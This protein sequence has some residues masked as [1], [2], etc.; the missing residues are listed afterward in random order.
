MK[1]F[2]QSKSMYAWEAIEDGPYVPRTEDGLDLP[3]FQWTRY[4][5]ERVKEN[6][7]AMNMI[8]C[9]L[10]TQEGERVAVC[11]SAKEMWEK[12]QITYEGTNKV[13]DAKIDL[14]IEQI[15]TFKMQHGESV[16]DL[17]NRYLNLANELKRLGK[18]Y[19][20]EEK[21][22]KILRSLTKE[23]DN[24]KTAIEEAKDLKAYTYD[25]LI[26][27]LL[28]HDMTH[29][30]Y[31]AQAKELKEEKK[32]NL[33]LRAERS[34]SDSSTDDE[35]DMAAFARKFRRFMRKE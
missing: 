26:G 33:V 32:K 21:V 15:E 11:E 12:L 6:A 10:N 17:S 2:I 29:K 13:K 35:D 34:G 24:K 18:S 5:Y 9:G 28:T 19:T 7:N 14:L 20:E 3:K 23:W 22:K 8:A 25:E 1:C 30:R 27:N 31:E 4:D 16:N